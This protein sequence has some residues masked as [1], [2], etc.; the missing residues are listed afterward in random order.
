MSASKPPIPLKH[1]P[2]LVNSHSSCHDSVLLVKFFRFTLDYC[3]QVTRCFLFIIHRSL[4]L[5]IPIVLPTKTINDIR[6][7]SLKYLVILGQHWC[8]VC[9]NRQLKCKMNEI[10]AIMGLEFHAPLIIWKASSLV[11]LRKKKAL[12]LGTLCMICYYPFYII[13][14]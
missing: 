6:G 14:E 3:S 10:S 7:L 2:Y 12:T 11:I 1:L 5:S 8:M 4:L 9:L 13:S